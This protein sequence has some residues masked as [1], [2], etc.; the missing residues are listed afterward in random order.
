[1]R[2]PI[3]SDQRE[4]LMV[5]RLL[6]RRHPGLMSPTGHC[7]YAPGLAV[8]EALARCEYVCWALPCLKA[9]AQ[10]AVTSPVGPVTSLG[11]QTARQ[12]TSPVGLLQASET[13]RASFAGPVPPS[14]ACLA[15][16]NV[17]V[18]CQMPSPV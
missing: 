13:R 17:H 15:C 4:E 11:E 8:P 16:P 3:S 1:M 5:F 12:V 7:P 10:R 14:R 9:L 2:N 6:G 18:A